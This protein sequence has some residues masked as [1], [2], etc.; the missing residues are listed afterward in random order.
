MLVVCS[1]AVVGMSGYYVT[2]I[3]QRRRAQ[4]EWLF[5]TDELP[6]LTPVPRFQ[7]LDPGRSDTLAYD[8]D[9]RAL[10]PMQRQ[11]LASAIASANRM[12][13][14]EAQRLVETGL[15]PIEARG[16]RLVGDD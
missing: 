11:R 15:I 10:H 1:E 3:D 2:A 14:R 6:V 12:P 9:T 4:W 8:L 5:G 16:C 7:A 13:S